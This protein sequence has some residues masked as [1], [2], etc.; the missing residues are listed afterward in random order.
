MLWELAEQQC[1]GLGARKWVASLEVMGM[2][3]FA[4]Q[5]RETDWC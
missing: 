5:E 1:I 3:V 2:Q 4:C